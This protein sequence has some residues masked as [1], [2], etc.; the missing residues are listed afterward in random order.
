MND[1][2]RIEPLDLAASHLLVR[3]GRAEPVGGGGEFWQ[4]LASDG[5][6]AERIGQGWLVASFDMPETWTTWEMHPDGD[7]IVYVESGHLRLVTEIGDEL[8]HVD[9]AAG[10]TVVIP[11]GVWHTVDIIEPA[12]TLNV[13]FG[14]DTGHRPR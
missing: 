6:F 7:E 8:D 4:R 1:T 14:R 13:T 5:G 11:A 12:R 3:D 10:H 9:L 2:I